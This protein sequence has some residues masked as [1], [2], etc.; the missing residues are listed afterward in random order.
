MAKSAK[1]PDKSSIG[2]F[3]LIKTRIKSIFNAI[4][5]ARIVLKHVEACLSE[6]FALSGEEITTALPATVDSLESSQPENPAEVSL[7]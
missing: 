3:A 4:R 1:S 7:G 6:I 5:L 2:R